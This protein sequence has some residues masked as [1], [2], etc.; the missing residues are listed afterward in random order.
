LSTPALAAAPL[1][2][3][4][5]TP[6]HEEI[7]ALHRLGRL[8]GAGEL[9]AAVLALIAKP[10][11][12]REKQAWREETAHLAH[13]ATVR[14]DVRKLSRV[15]RLP[16]L[17]RALRSF[18]GFPSGERKKLLASA[19][20]VMSADGQVDPLDRLRWLTMHHLLGE[21]L[22]RKADTS[23]R[24]QGINA[25]SKLAD[26]QR[27]DIATFTAFL[28]RLVPMSDPRAAVGSAGARWYQTVLER[29]WDRGSYPPCQVPDPD[30]LARALW[31]VQELSWML[32]PVLIRTW[33]DEA[34]RTSEPRVLREEAAGALRLTCALLNTPMP[35]VLAKSFV[36][37]PE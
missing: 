17:E 4:S 36:E 13:A 32:H 25:V 37:C 23:A 15:T 24:S 22:P 30:A 5:H 7:E 21:A 19:R 12:S 20:R 27:N 2:L 18:A 1:L 8:A 28:A 6:G 9:R 33:V 35:P 16:M 14:A 3:L 10:G 31:N 29:W 26:A 34:V 11:S